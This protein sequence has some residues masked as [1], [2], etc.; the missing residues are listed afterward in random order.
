M[1]LVC[2]L[3]ATGFVGDVKGGRGSGSRREHGTVGH[4][5]EEEG[6]GDVWAQS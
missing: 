4:P 1:K 5:M 3:G 2:F 6:R